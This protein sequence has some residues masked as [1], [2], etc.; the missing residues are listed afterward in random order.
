ML[1]SAPRSERCRRCHE[2]DGVRKRPRGAEIVASL[3]HG[4]FSELNV[5]VRVRR[6][7]WPLKHREHSGLQVP[8]SMTFEALPTWRCGD[9]LP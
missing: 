8:R 1:R 5:P 4:G 9:V 3:T 2:R 7:G 6:L